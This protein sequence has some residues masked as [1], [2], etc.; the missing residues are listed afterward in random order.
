MLK[1]VIGLCL[2]YKPHT[3]DFS[4]QLVLALREKVEGLLEYCE[5][6]GRIEMYLGGWHQS[7]S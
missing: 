5:R 4:E 3:L 7:V 2:H 6:E 1:M